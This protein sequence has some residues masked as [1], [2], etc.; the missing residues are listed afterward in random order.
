M[1]TEKEKNNKKKVE[2][3]IQVYHLKKGE[4]IFTEKD[5]KEFAQSTS[6]LDIRIFHDKIQ[7][8]IESIDSLAKTPIEQ[9]ILLRAVL[10]IKESLSTAKFILKK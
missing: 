8:L 7:R 3:F 9:K 10:D 4:E 5:Y 6:F 2:D 1:L